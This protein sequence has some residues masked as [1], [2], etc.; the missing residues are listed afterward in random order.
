MFWMR[1]ACLSL[2][3]GL[4]SGCHLFSEHGG[5]DGDYFEHAHEGR[6]YVFGSEESLNG[7]KETQHM[8]YTYT[9]I[10][11]G[12]NGETL[13]FEVDTDD[14]SLQERLI[15]AYEERKGG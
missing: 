4:F 8:P 11:E 3:L 5:G 9:M 14:P 10:G 12:P 6:I 13:V 7:F 15:A 1:L 2:T